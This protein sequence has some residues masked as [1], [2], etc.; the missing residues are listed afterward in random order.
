VVVGENLLAV[1]CWPDMGEL[2]VLSELGKR[3]GWSFFLRST[4]SVANDKRAGLLPYVRTDASGFARS[5]AIKFN[6]SAE[7]IL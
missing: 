5:Y 1:L 2:F 6:S 4:V 3:K 7:V